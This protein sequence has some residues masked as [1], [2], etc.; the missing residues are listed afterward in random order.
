MSLKY[1]HRFH[2]GNFADVHKHITLIAILDAMRRKDAGL[3]FID[4]HAGSGRYELGHGELPAESNDGVEALL[5]TEPAPQADEIG[6]YLQLVGADRQTHGAHSYPGSPLLASALLRPQDRAVFC[7][8]EPEAVLALRRELAAAAG[9]P[10]DERYRRVQHADGFKE[11]NAWL[12]PRERRGLLLI[13]P[14]F[15]NAQQDFSSA[16]AALES[17]QRKFATGVAMFW[18]PIKDDTLSGRFLRQVASVLTRPWLQIELWR[19]P[20]D[21]RVSLNGS[22]LMVVNPPYLLEERM[23]EWLPQL[24]HALAAAAGGWTVQRHSAA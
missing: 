7:D 9:A 12:P 1:L 5:R 23:R 6:R 21:N 16:L 20:R 4:T 3:L 8:L 10:L 22:G 15:E 24:Q 14:P 2:A 13:D 18:Y 11:L 17:A 19:F